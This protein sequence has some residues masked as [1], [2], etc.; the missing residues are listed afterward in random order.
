MTAQL[1]LPQALQSALDSVTRAVVA[2]IYTIPP[3]PPH[4]VFDP[5]Q[6][7]VVYTNG[8]QIQYSVVRSDA[9]PCLRGWHYINNEAELEI[10]GETC[11]LIQSDP[12]A[13]V[14][15]FFG[16]GVPAVVN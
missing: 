8:S 9:D 11:A 16:C 5:T 4:Q 13:Q 15:L 2:C 12:F 6:T 3:F 10:C 1:D 14:D 7:T